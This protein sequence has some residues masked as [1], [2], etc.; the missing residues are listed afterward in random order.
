AIYYLCLTKS[1]FNSVDQQ[2]ILFGRDFFRLEGRFMKQNGAFEV[3][4]KLPTNKRKELLIN[5]V[6]VPK[7]SDH[8]GN[9]PCIIISPDD[10]Q[11]ILGSSEERRRFLDGTLSQINHE[12]LEWLIAYNKVLTQRNAA[13]KRFAETHK[14]DRQ[15]LE[16]YNSQLIPLGSKIYEARKVVIQKL[17]PVFQK[18][19]KEISLE[20]EVVNFSYA[21]QLNDKTFDELLL[22]GTERDL[23][24]QRTDTGI[25]KDDIE[26]FITPVD[27]QASTSKIKKFGSQGQQKS[28]IIALKFAQYELI[29]NG[30]AVNTG[31]ELK[32]LLLI[33][34]IFDKLDN[35]RSQKLIELIAGEDLGQVF[36][37][38]TDD[39]H[40]RQ[41]LLGREGLF[42]VINV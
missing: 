18:Y 30:I 5:D 33:D 15:L 6:A 31:L 2:N 37:T 22:A 3:V 25:H 21:S 35:D 13:L 17:Q 1:Y 41:A 23:V 29:K 39:A 34:D 24:L 7:L 27:T 11:L 38:D 4:Y 26:F 40:I 42:E 10:S 9:F 8:I 14:V 16:T 20:R 32:P 12:Y 36:L 19:Y 28:F